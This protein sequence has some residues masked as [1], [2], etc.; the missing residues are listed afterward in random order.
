MFIF[1]VFLKL[2]FPQIIIFCLFIY[3]YK[4]WNLS[5]SKYQVWNEIGLVANSKIVDVFLL[6]R[7]WFGHWEYLHALHFTGDSWTWK[8]LW[9]LCNWST[10]LTASDVVFA[11][12]AD[13]ISLK[14]WGHVLTSVLFAENV[15]LRVLNVSLTRLTKYRIYSMPFVFG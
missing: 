8:K 10:R 9:R 5:E 2:R 15:H 3:L 1:H 12:I 11:G 14:D 4:C 13:C 7:W 6:E